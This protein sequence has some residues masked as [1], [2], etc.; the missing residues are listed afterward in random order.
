MKRPGG[1]RDVL[2][3]LR[4][5]LESLCGL[6]ELKLSRCGI[7]LHGDRSCFE[8]FKA[9]RVQETMKHAHARAHAWSAHSSYA[10]VCEH[11]WCIAMQRR[12]AHNNIVSGIYRH[13]E[14]GER[15]DSPSFLASAFGT[16]AAEVQSDG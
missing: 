7:C 1:S 11:E 10:H 12:S 2:F 4:F 3:V 9:G 15:P 14:L 13:L 16:S 6:G 8:V 5:D